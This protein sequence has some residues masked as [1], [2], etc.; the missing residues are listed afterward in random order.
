MRPSFVS[1]LALGSA[2][3]AANPLPAFTDPASA[4]EDFA[5]QGEYSGEGC[6]A[7]VIA[8]G[9]GKFH[10]VGWVPSLPGAGVEAERK[11]ELDAQ[12]EGG[13]VVF[14][15][16]EWQD[17]IGDGVIDGTNRDGKTWQLRRVERQSPTLGAKPPA[18]AVILFDGT[19]AHAWT[20][21]QLTAEG[22]LQCG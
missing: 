22:W 13:R 1:I 18:G 19:S 15:S 17:V 12:R 7:H 6:A 20:D 3:L 16:E 8:L 9:D 4:G 14:K 21:G 5:V 2:A 11:V 10:I